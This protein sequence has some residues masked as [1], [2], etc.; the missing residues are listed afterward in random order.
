MKL[1]SVHEEEW[2]A[3]LAAPRTHLIVRLMNFP[4]RFFAPEGWDTG[5]VALTDHLVYLAVRGRCRVML[6]GQERAIRAGDI[7]WANPGTRIR[8]FRVAGETQP[9]LYRFRFSLIEGGRSLRLPWDYRLCQVGPEAL[10][11]ARQW[12]EESEHPGVYSQPRMKSLAIL[13]SLAVFEGFRDGEEPSGCR[14]SREMC[15][16]L[17]DWVMQHS[18]RR[19]KPSD[20]A[21][22]CG[23]SPD[24]FSRLFRRSFRISPRAWILK[25]RL[26]YASGMLAESDQSVSAIAGDLGYEDLYLFS[27]QFKKEFGLSPRAWRKSH[28][29]S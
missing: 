2:V 18:S 11:W 6:A 17:T 5:D 16:N 29:T 26:R 20:L 28:R 14:L 13:F 22:R 15:A 24:Y 3:R 4:F 19:F 8:L 23:L 21:S 1:K 9:Q 25:Q 7:Y 27:R 10:D 12:V